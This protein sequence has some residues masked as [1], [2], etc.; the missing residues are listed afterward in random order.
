MFTKKRVGVL[1]L[2]LL[3]GVSFLGNMVSAADTNEEIKKFFGAVGGSLE[4]IVG[5]L[6]GQEWG[7][8]FWDLVFVKL[9]FFFLL[10]LI[11]FAVAGSIPLL[12]SSKPWIKY[13]FSLIVSYLSVMYITPQEFYS[14]LISYT[15]L[16]I[17]IT[18]L[19]PLAILFGL[20]YKLSESPTAGTLIL[21][22]LLL[23]LYAFVLV[24][25]LIQ[26]AYLESNEIPSFAIPLY[27]G[28][29]IIVGF[30]LIFNKTVRDFIFSSK[31][32]GYVEVAGKLNKDEMLGQVLLL[33]KK[34]DALEEAGA[35]EPARQLRAAATRIENNATD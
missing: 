30:L 17:V 16:G 14:I 13:S 25:R 6:F 4:S 28:S 8:G 15:T 11:I 23:G 7:T 26:I 20:I 32:K 31:M 35:V 22:K 21:Q 3:L 19:V 1:C 33:R 27:G 34:A 5:K 9:L 29:L 2:F 18:T 10:F 12:S 24:W